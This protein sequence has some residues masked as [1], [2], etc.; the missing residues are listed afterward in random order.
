MESPAKKISTAYG[1]YLGISLV[2]IT[3]L[4]YAFNL[5]LFTKWWF[6]ITLIIFSIVLASVSISKAKK[7]STTLFSFKDAFGSYFLTIFIGTFISL[8]FGIILFNLIDPEAA[9]KLTE[10]IMESSRAMMERFGAP[11]AQINE[12]LRKMQDENQFSLLNQLKGYGFQLVLY[13]IFGLIIS[14]IF[15]EKETINA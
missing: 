2:L 14:L 8:I 13:A 5:A 4:T 9:E 3:V 6:G 11:E 1:V 12:A 10:L 7:V 15:R